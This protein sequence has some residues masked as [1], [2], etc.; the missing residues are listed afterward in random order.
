MKTETTANLKILVAAALQ[1][2]NSSQEAI[3]CVKSRELNS[4]LFSKL[5][6]RKDWGLNL[7]PG[8]REEESPEWILIAKVEKSLIKFP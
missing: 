4:L 6:Y 1:K 8:H 2:R 7:R 5:F 3:E